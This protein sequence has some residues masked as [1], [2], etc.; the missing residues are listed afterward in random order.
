MVA[1]VA[2]VARSRETC[3]RTRRPIVAG[4]AV[5]L[6][7]TYKVLNDKVPKYNVDL[8]QSYTNT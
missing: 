2:V 3:T 4:A 1:G 5:V 7:L 8:L 6:L